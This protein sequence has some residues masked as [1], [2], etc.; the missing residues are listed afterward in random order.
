MFQR[1]LLRSSAAL[2][3]SSR[4]QSTRPSFGAGLQVYDMEIQKPWHAAYPAPR[5][6]DPDG[7]SSSQ[8][9]DLL[10]QR[11]ADEA[12]G[13]RSNFVLVDLRRN[14]HQ[15]HEPIVVLCFRTDSVVLGRYY[16]RLHQPSR[17]KSLSCHPPALR[18]VP[19]CRCPNRHMVLR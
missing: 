3:K 8:V 11:A 13:Q 15:V 6:A 19:G 14:D 16:S 7:L 17:A 9:L 12:R 2:V 18:P 4:F 1:A 10:R 5:N